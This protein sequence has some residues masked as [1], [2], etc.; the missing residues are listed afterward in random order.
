MSKC[1]SPGKKIGKSPLTY[2]YIFKLF[3]VTS[4]IVVTLESAANIMVR[5][6]K[7]RT[8]ITATM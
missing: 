7:I 2:I 1:I 3:Y 6:N 4:N 8:L 5:Y